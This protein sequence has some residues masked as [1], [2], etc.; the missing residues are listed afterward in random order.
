MVEWN[1]MNA[2]TGTLQNSDIDRYTVCYDA[3]GNKTTIEIFTNDFHS[4]SKI[5][6]SGGNPHYSDMTGILSNTIDST[7]RLLRQNN[8]PPEA[9]SMITGI[10]MVRQYIKAEPAFSRVFP[11]ASLHFLGEKEINH[12]ASLGKSSGF[13]LHAGTGSYVSYLDGSHSYYYGGLG[14][15]LGDE[16]GG[17]DIG[18]SG[19]KAA[20]ASF[21]KR[22]PKTLLEEK[23]L[24]HRT[25]DIF[26]TLDA[27]CRELYFPSAETVKKIASISKTV[28]ECA[29][30]G[31][32]VAIRIYH[33]AAADLIS[34]LSSLLRTTEIRPDGIYGF[35][36][37]AVL[38]SS[39]YRRIV[40]E[41][42]TELYPA[43]HFTEQR[44]TPTES[45]YHLAHHDIS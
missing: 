16:G 38:K 7:C 20:F 15:Y 37:S 22:G 21:G 5:D 4:V 44:Y 40:Q 29:M 41:N 8:I 32:D 18:L 19:L 23:L 39:I 42:I 30:A 26:Q 33:R 6:I 11:N 24:S 43:L 14:P 13:I 28:D 9:V 25:A 31:D 35:S 12:F 27:A 10:L 2:Q 17:Y 3:G 34:Y 36:G 1:R 45:A